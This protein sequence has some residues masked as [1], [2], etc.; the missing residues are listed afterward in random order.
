MVKVTYLGTAASKT[1]FVM[2]TVL[3]LLVTVGCEHGTKKSTA[4][5]AQRV[6][7]LGQHRGG[8]IRVLK[9]FRHA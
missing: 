7:E 6:R 9:L 5:M 8:S 3:V 4:A 1:K 2:G